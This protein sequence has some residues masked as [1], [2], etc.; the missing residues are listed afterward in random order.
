MLD[1]ETIARLKGEVLKKTFNNSGSTIENPN[2]VD[3]KTRNRLIEVVNKEKEKP[4]KF[5]QNVINFY[6]NYISGE[7]KTEFPNMK[8]IYQAGNKF[9]A[10]NFKDSA[11]SSINSELRHKIEEQDSGEITE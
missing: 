2:E 3:E 4:N 7:A 8:E 1:E 9:S 11:A 10:V 5:T 6:D